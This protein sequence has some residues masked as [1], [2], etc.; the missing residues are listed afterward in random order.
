MARRSG[1]AAIEFALDVSL[2]QRESRRT[3]VDDAADRRSVRF[4][5]RC[6]A[7]E[8]AEGVA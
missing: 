7:E 8:L 5:E 4:T 2:G 6:D 1:L 3:A